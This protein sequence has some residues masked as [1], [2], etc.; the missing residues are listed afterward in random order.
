MAHSRPTPQQILTDLPLEAAREATWQGF[1]EAQ[2]Q[3]PLIDA[4]KNIVVG[5]VGDGVLRAARTVAAQFERQGDGT[6][7]SFSSLPVMAGVMETGKAKL[8]NAE[9]IADKVESVLARGWTRTP[10]FSAPFAPPTPA[11]AP[12]ATVYDASAWNDTA[13]V[14]LEKFGVPPNLSQDLPPAPPVSPLPQ[15]VT[16]QSVAPRAPMAA[17]IAAPG[18]P[19]IGE[20]MPSYGAVMPTKQGTTLIIYGVLGMLCCQ[21][22][23]PFTV[24]YATKALKTYGELDPGDKNLVVIARI[25]GVIGTIFLVLRLLTWIG[26]A[27]SPTYGGG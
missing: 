17:P 8:K 27:V 15:P 21:I 16:P 20:R 9:K 3:S 19:Q 2:V 26:S 13:R 10:Q 12:D 22:L 11:T 4:D 5:T 25:L 18:A 23:A 14:E 7:I 6:L 24:Y 1:V